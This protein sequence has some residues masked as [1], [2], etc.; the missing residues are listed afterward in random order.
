MI[1]QRDELQALECVVCGELRPM[2]RKVLRDP[3]AVFFLK[4]S[5]AEDHS[6]CALPVEDR[7]AL[8]REETVQKLDA[9]WKR[10]MDKLRRAA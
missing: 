2:T 8:E 4:E 9:H 10:E 3:E 1:V 6:R 5:M 7:E